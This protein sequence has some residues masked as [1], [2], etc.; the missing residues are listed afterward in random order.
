MFCS[1]LRSIMNKDWL[2]DGRKIPNEVMGY[3]RKSAVQAI[4]ENGQSP[5]LVA[6]VLNFNRSCIYDWLKRYDQGGYE[7]LESRR[8]PGAKPLINP[9][10]GELA[11]RDGVELHTGAAGIGYEPLDP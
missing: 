3:I 1:S 2:V 10:D 4:R 6:K 9:G 7:A 8:P 11:R 5:E